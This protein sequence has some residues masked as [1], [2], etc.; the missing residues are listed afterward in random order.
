M[1]VKELIEKLK[2]FDENLEV[3]LSVKNWE[4]GESF[5]IGSLDEIYFE[6]GLDEIVLTEL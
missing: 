6:E 1:K 4:Y 2:D 3:A 5:T